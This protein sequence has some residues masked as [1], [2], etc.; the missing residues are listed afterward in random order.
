MWILALLVVAL[1][2]ISYLLYR[3]R[4]IEREKQQEL[5]ESGNDDATAQV[6]KKSISALYRLRKRQFIPWVEV[7]E[8]T[9]IIQF[10]AEPPKILVD[11][12][13]RNRQQN[14]KFNAE[15]LRDVVT[16]LLAALETDT[17][18]PLISTVVVSVYTPKKDKTGNVHK[19]CIMSAKCCKEL[20]GS[21]QLE[22]VLGSIDGIQTLLNQI[23]IQFSCDQDFS[24][25][26]VTPYERQ[27]RKEI[28]Q[29]RRKRKDEE[30]EKEKEKEIAAKEVETLKEIAQ[31]EKS[32][33]REDTFKIIK[34]MNSDEFNRLVGSAEKSSQR[35]LETLSKEK[36]SED[37]MQTQEFI[38]LGKEK[39]EVNTVSVKCGVCDWTYQKTLK[40]CPACAR[41][42]PSREMSNISLVTKG[43]RFPL[44]EQ[45][46]GS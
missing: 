33:V 15:L 3:N 31:L 42:N 36:S 23:D 13:H 21:V 41:Q 7:L 14:R 5:L 39:R 44:S 45:E 19:V 9:A 17:P 32:G 34:K 2:V 37:L 11:D 46:I 18:T 25:L 35:S 29:Q 24:Y 12:R 20:K 6:I 4:K 1:L 38:R 43:K 16:L 8:D 28:E 22:N 27:L 30:K 40:E 26:K 10:D